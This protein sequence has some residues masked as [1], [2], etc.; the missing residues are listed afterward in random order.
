MT[1]VTDQKVL[2]EYLCNWHSKVVSPGSVW[3]ATKLLHIRLD[4]ITIAPEIKIM[5]YEKRLRFCN[6]FINHVHDEILDPKLTFFTDEGD[7]NF[8]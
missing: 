5:D 1:S 3:P 6:W 8:S 4:K 2:L 7:F